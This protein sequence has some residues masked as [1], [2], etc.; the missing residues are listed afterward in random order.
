MNTQMVWGGGGMIS[1]TYRNLLENE[2]LENVISFKLWPICS[3]QI[4]ATSHDRFP[5]NGG[6]L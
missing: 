4:L 1:L 6:E 3:G 5:K 2:A